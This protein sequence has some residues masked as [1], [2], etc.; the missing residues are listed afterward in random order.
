MALPGALAVALTFIN[1]D[2]MALLFHEKMGQ[3]MLI[4]AVVM[5]MIGYVWIRKVI[6][7]EV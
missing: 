3:Q 1:P 6:K 2:H 5:Q 4:G 7:I